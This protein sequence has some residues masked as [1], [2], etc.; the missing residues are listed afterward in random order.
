MKNFLFSFLGTGN[1][2]PIMIS[3]NHSDI[4]QLA[5]IP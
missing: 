4:S 1:A 5:K 3:K 2:W